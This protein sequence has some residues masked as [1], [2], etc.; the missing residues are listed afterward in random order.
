MSWVVE[1]KIREGLRDPD[2]L[3][4]ALVFATHDQARSY[5]QDLFR[6]WSAVTDVRVVE[7]TVAPTHRWDETEGAVQL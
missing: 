3:G 5:A 2:W 6:R 4:N 1:V 7:S